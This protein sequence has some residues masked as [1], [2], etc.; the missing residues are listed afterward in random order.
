[1]RALQPILP[2][3]SR[4]M[5]RRVRRHEV[6]PQLARRR[7]ERAADDLLHG[8]RVQV[9][10]GAETRHGW[11]ASAGIQGAQSGEV[12]EVVEVG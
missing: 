8:A 3:Q 10:A 7:R 2:I 6:R 11:D 5:A 4:E 12:V 1:M 9:D